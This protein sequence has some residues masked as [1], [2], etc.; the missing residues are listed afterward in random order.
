MY[1]TGNHLKPHIEFWL[2]LFSLTHFSINSN[3]A[4]HSA[5][6]FPTSCLLSISQRYTTSP[7]KIALNKT[8]ENEQNAVKVEGIFTSLFIF[9]FYIHRIFKPKTEF[10]RRNEY[11]ENGK[12]LY[13][14][15]KIIYSKLVTYLSY[16]VFYFSSASSCS[17]FSSIRLNENEWNFLKIFLHLVSYIYTNGF[18]NRIQ[19]SLDKINK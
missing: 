14:R 4:L 11:K 9:L 15:M 12:N 17:A 16:F 3:F 1:T 13:C 5:T 18:L 19:F 10:S 2:F 7:M 8:P 6:L